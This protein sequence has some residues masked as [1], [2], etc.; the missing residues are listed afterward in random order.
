MINIATAVTR[1]PLKYQRACH[2]FSFRSI[3][4]GT[5]QQLAIQWSRFSTTFRSHPKWDHCHVVV[6]LLK[7][8]HGIALELRCATT[9]HW[10]NSYIA[11]ASDKTGLTLMDRHDISITMMGAVEK[12]LTDGEVVGAG[13]GNWPEIGVI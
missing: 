5:P 1:M 12:M 3:V 13:C 9:S 4:E 6:S 8:F 7:P 10:P 11:E 2:V